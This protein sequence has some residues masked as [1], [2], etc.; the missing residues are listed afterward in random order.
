MKSFR[1]PETEIILRRYVGTHFLIRALPVQG[2]GQPGSCPGLQTT[3][4]H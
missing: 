1:F 3:G 2:A 4:G